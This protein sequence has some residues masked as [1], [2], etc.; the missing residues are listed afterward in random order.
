LVTGGLAY[1]VM[2]RHGRDD[3]SQLEAA[4]QQLP[5]HFSLGY[6][7]TTTLLI[8][9]NLL[10]LLFVTIQFAYLFGG[11][12]YLQVENFSYADYA[13]RGFF[14][15]LAVAILSLGLILG[16][17]WL[18]RRESKRQIKLFNWLSTFLV[19][20]VLVML[21]SAFQRMKLYET[22]FGYTELRLLVYVFIVWLA[23][24]LVWFIYTLWRRPDRFAIGVFLAALGF[25]I[26]L[27][28]LNPDAF[29]AR[30]NLN[31]YVATG[32][33]DAIYLTSL[34]DDAVPQIVRALHLT[35]G[36][37]ER[38]MMPSCADPFARVYEDD[39]YAAPYEIV[40]A[41][42][43]GRYQSMTDHHEWRQWQSF[44]LAHWQAFMWLQEI[45]D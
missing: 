24:L 14:E 6:I 43:N 29:I 36:D 45:G 13:R 25:L 31:R 40:L 41:E 11:V 33:L 2:R 42:V 18:A 26:T 17:N 4:L 20:F 7:E 8:T 32:N 28:L 21:A 23:V 3:Q 35:D 19:G 16:L 30:Q 27:N 1:G 22:E 39:C 12:A 10:F 15:L 38:Q 44:H 5:Q 37:T 34:S 9:V